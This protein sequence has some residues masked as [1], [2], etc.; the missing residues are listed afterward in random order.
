M[1]NNFLMN[2]AQ[3]NGKKKQLYVLLNVVKCHS[4]TT[5][6]DLWI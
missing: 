1:E 3:M 6:F 2:T 4:A 5:S